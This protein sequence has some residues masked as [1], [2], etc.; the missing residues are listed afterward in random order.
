MSCS[1]IKFLILALLA[2]FLAQPAHA[3]RDKELI[4]RIQDRYEGLKS[5][6]ANFDQTLLHKESGSQEKRN[7]RLLF[8]KPL[9]IR[10][11]TEKPHEETLIATDR[12]IWDYLPDEEIAYRYSPELIKDSRSIIQVITGQ[13]ALSKDFQVKGQGSEGNLAKLALYPREPTTQMVEAT[14]WVDPDS[15]FIKRARIVDFYGNENDVRFTRFDPDAAIAASQ[16]KFTPPANVEVE[17]RLDRKVLEK[18]L[19]N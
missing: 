17:D 16:F 7:G 3:A 14:I 6:T 2:I 11:Q 1:H 5:F 19:F 9:Q 18:D 10:W 4:A 12:E 13:A 15:G 8:K